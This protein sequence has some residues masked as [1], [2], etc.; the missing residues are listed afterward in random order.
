MKESNSKNLIQEWKNQN[1][2]KKSNHKLLKRLSDKKIKKLDEIAE[3]THDEVFT[4]IDCLDCAN[5]CKS[6]PPIV[7]NTDI[8][9]ISKHLGLSES[10]FA[11]KYVTQDT[12]GD[13]V[14]NASPCPFLGEGNLC[15]IYDVRPKACRQ[16]P[17]TD[18]FEFRKNAKLHA[19]NATYC[20]GVYHILKRLDNIV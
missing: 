12:D 9:R 5:C 14:M 3:H 8:K 1:I 6:I 20:P 17:H 18:N 2:S 15:D 19:I 16:Y 4:D 11:S 10:G 7:L 13:S